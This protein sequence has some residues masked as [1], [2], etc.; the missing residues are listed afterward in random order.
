MV[1]STMEWS[2]LSAKLPK[3]SRCRTALNWLFPCGRVFRFWSLSV[4]VPR[5]PVGAGDLAAPDS[6]SSDA[7][8]GTPSPCGAD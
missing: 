1:E 6:G 3:R 7:P 2:G 5:P 4:R 8:K